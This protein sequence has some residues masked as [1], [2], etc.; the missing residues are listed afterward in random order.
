MEIIRCPFCSFE[1]AGDKQLIGRRVQCYRCR[2]KFS[3]GENL[4]SEVESNTQMDMNAAPPPMKTEP[5]LNSAPEEPEKLIS[6]SEQQSVAV[7]ESRAVKEFSEKSS[8]VTAKIAPVDYDDGI[9]WV[10]NRILLGAAIFG[11]VIFIAAF[12]VRWCL[13]DSLDAAQKA[14][15]KAEYEELKKQ[16]DEK[17]ERQS[18]MIQEDDK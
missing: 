2:E 11:A 13:R 12:T 5:A 14:L 3:V 10:V 15:E 6:Q 7:A 18:S 8:S 17:P 4:F 1:L 9:N 16:M